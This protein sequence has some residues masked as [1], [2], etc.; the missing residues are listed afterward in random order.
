MRK[1]V[2]ELGADSHGKIWKVLVTDRGVPADRVWFLVFP[3]N[4]H[5][6]NVNWD[7]PRVLEAWIQKPFDTKAFFGDIYHAHHF[8]E[9]FD[10]LSDPRTLT[11]L[12]VHDCDPGSKDSR[13]GKWEKRGIALLLLEYVEQWAI[14]SGI[15]TLYGFISKHDDVERLKVF[16]SKRGY[17]ISTVSDE[18][19]RLHGS[20]CVAKATKKLRG[21][22]SLFASG[23]FAREAPPPHLS[24]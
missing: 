21:E 11:D 5:W 22:W 14:Q 18:E 2:R 16:W 1:V 15:E 17:S 12:R 10:Q 7:S 3:R 23:Q 8:S 4:T 9:R 20:F 24:K 6:K 13:P 19:K